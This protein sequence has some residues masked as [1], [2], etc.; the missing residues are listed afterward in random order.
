V[1]QNLHIRLMLN[2]KQFSFDQENVEKVIRYSQQRGIN[3]AGVVRQLSAISES[4]DRTLSLQKLQIPSLIIIVDIDSLVPVEYGIV[5]AAAI[6]G[7]TLKILQ[8]MGHTLPIQLWP[9]I[10]EDI[11]DLSKAG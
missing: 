1:A 9:Q 6:P 4:P 11:V 2:G 7:A 3:P 5:N 10:V 8:G